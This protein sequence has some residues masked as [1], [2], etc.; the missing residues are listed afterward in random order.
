MDDNKTDFM[1]WVKDHRKQLA[2]A[3]ISVAAIIGVVVCLRNRREV[4]NLWSSLIERVKNESRHNAIIRSN[5]TET[6]L[7][8]T[9]PTRIYTR[10]QEPV[11]VS[12]HI[13]VLATG[14]H[15][16]AEKEMEARAMGIYLKPNETWVAPYTKYAA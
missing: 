16:S 13:R 9:R 14:K 6:E 11:E 12:Q 5:V 3:G 15:H 4:A 8:V 1:Q 10:P 2:V 7:E